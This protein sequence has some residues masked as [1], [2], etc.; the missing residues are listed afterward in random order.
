MVPVIARTNVK[1]WQAAMKAWRKA[2]R[3]VSHDDCINKFG[4]E[5][6]LRAI[7]FT[8]KTRVNRINTY[9]PSK[10]GKTKKQKLLFALASNAG[11]RKGSGGEQVMYPY[12]QR[13]FKKR[14]SS[15]GANKAGFLN[16]ARDLG[17]RVTSS[18][19]AGKSASKSKG[20]KSARFRMKAYSFNEVDGAGKVA[21]APMNRAMEFVAMR[22]HNWAINRLQKANNTFSAKAF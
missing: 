17:A 6:C 15:I 19:Y 2:K 21:Y 7:S 16:P 3:G 8:P 11:I 4:S 14:K 10:G 22:E 12:V 9:D 13:I 18:P 5:S 20:I 1:Q